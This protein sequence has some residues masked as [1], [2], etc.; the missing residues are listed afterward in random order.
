MID[1]LQELFHALFALSHKMQI[2][3][4]VIMAIL[5][6]LAKS[7]VSRQTPNE[8]T[9]ITAGTITLTTYSLW[10]IMKLVAEITAV[11]SLVVPMFWAVLLH[12]FMIYRQS[13]DFFSNENS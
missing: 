10:A 7:V 13:L 9:M 2:V 3:Y 8:K 4:L 5:L 6:L 12:L 11:E 1:S